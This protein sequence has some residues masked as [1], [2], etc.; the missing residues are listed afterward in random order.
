MAFQ[1]QHGMTVNGLTSA[2]FWH[3]LFVAAA[4]GRRNAVGYTYAIAS[5]GSPETLTIWHDGRH[6]LRGLANTGIGIAPTA[7]G[8][9]PVYLRYRYQG[10]SR[11]YPD[12]SHYADPASF[13]SYLD[14]V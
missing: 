3:A 12:G 11:T 7:S 1:S 2:K 13:V 10:M 6:V 9:F 8:T 14:G 5:K 4:T